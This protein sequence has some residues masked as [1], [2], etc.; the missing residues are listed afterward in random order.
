MN[1]AMIYVHG[2]GGTTAEAEYYKKFFPA[3]EVIGV[4]YPS[5]LPWI[6][7]VQV[8]EVYDR[9]KETHDEISLITNSIGT[10]F[11]MLSLQGRNIKKAYCVSTILN[12]E[13]LITDMMKWANVSEAELQEK[14][15][16]TTSFGETLSWEY[17]C[18]VRNNPIKWDVNTAILYAGGDNLTS[19][20]TVDKFV[21]SHDASFMVMEN[22]EHWF[23]TVEQLAFL[24]EWMEQE[25]I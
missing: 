3:H 18:F 11:A 10:Y 22:G 16:I 8:R 17:L 23:H 24:D 20:Q 7:S 5:K 13:R 9:L 25:K 1:Q 15:E 6:A 14:K 19:R 2:K 21:Q 4:D 12:M